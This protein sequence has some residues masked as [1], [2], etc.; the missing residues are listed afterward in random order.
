MLPTVQRTVCLF[1]PVWQGHFGYF[2]WAYSPVFPVEQSHTALV[3]TPVTTTKDQPGKTGP[4]APVSRHEA[5]Q[6]RPP[7]QCTCFPPGL[8]GEQPRY[9]LATTPAT[10]TSV[11]QRVG[12]VNFGSVLSP[13]SPNHYGRTTSPLQRLF[14]GVFPTTAP[15]LSQLLP[16]PTFFPLV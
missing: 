8:P 12:P 11:F 7:T 10:S 2:S 3:H 6:S 5:F 9:G 16:G 15:L 1:F 14:T 4:F 13:V